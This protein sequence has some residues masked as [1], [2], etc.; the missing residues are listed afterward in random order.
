M[1]HN[2]YMSIFKNCSLENKKHCKTPAIIAHLQLI[3]D[4]SVSGEKTE[5]G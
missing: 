2:K 5:E 1:V 4:K 3:R